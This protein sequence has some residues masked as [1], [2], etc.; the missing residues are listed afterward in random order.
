MLF[1]SFRKIVYWGQLQN[2]GVVGERF[3]AP[4]G[5]AGQRLGEKRF[6][7]GQ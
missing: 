7:M 2:P 6:A 4:T 1:D 5:K 3:F